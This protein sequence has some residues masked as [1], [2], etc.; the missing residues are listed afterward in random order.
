MTIEQTLKDWMEST[1]KQLQDAT[2]QMRLMKGEDQF[3]YEHFRDEVQYLNGR[4]DAYKEVRMLF[5]EERL[6]IL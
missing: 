3:S 2:E 6:G 5:A 4:L 1:T